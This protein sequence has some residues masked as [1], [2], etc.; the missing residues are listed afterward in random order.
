MQKQTN[1]LNCNLHKCKNE[2]KITLVV[3]EGLAYFPL[4]EAY[5]YQEEEVELI[6]AVEEVVVHCFGQD[7]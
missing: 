7:Y 4:E 5:F 3:V 2:K 6:A 1:T